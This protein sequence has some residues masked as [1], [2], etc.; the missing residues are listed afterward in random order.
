MS[1]PL[2]AEQHELVAVARKLLAGPAGSLPPAWEARDAGADRALWRSLGELGLLGL[3]VAE[4]RGGSGGGMREL[5][6]VA[7]QVGIAVARIPFSGAAAVLAFDHEHADA[8]ARGSVLAI[9]AWETFPVVPGRRAAALELT[10]STVDGELRSVGFGMDADLVL[11][12]AGDTPV[13]VDLAGPGVAR[14]PR[15]AF[16]VTEPVASIRL[17]RAAATV[18]APVEY[19]PRTLTV[20]A[21]ELVGTGQRALDGAVEYAKQRHQ[22]GRAIGS[23]QAIKH[24]LADRHVQL[25]GTRLLV[26]RAAAAIDEGRPD[27]ELAARTALAAATEAAQRA[28]GDALQVHGGIGFTWEHPSHVFLKR[29]RARRSLFGSPARQLDSLGARLFAAPTGG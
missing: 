22:F 12:F 16:D 9:P 28:A 26:E 1:M 19:A 18:L 23:F 20:V 4:D 21:A 27:A 5:C 10:G 2:S 29:T 17:T 14:S 24:L 6:L 15:E 3:G 11:A 7:E 25:D 8:V 13:L